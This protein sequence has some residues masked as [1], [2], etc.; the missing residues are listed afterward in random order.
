MLL[1]SRRR[2]GSTDDVY[3]GDDDD[4]TACMHLLGDLWKG[5]D[6]WINLLADSTSPSSSLR[7]TGMRDVID[8]DRPASTT[9][10]ASDGL[11]N[12]ISSRCSE[13]GAM[14]W[15]LIEAM[16]MHTLMYAQLLV[17]VII[18]VELTRAFIINTSS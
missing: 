10:A 13:P 16:G 7:G 6:S 18:I 14:K 1:I 17:V 5:R 8:Q 2:K 4:G 9:A 15:P 12:S 3:I 11:L